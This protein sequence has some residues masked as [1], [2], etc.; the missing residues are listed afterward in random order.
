MWAT[1]VTN[2]WDLMQLQIM[3]CDRLLQLGEHRDFLQTNM[4]ISNYCMQGISVTTLVR[5][6]RSRVLFWIVVLKKFAKLKEKHL[7]IF[8][9]Y[10]IIDLGLQL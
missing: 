6:S 1:K 5:R 4:V 9:I 10:K 3:V 8:F 7:E 2:F